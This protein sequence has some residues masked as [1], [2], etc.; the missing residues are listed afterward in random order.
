[1][2]TV[3]EKG[4]GTRGKP[5]NGQPLAGKT[6]TS[7]EARDLWFV[8]YCPQLSTAIW[9]GYRDEQPTSGYGGS[10]SAPIFKIYADQGVLGE[11]EYFPEVDTKSLKFTNE[12]E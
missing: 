1:M 8:G 10:V 9:S 3:I 11:I 5:D 12:W 4:T 2:R 6:G 7:E